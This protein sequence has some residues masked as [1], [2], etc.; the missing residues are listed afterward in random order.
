MMNDIFEISNLINLLIP[1]GTD[2]EVDM[3]GVKLHITKKDGNVKIETI[4]EFDDS[5]I[6]AEIKEFQAKIKELD[7]DTF[8]EVCESVDFNINEF[9]KL[10]EL[11]DIN[12]KQAEEIDDC[13]TKF[14]QAVCSNLQKKIED[15][16]SVYQRF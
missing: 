10:I 2:K 12:E 9:N 7:D 16:V 8:A 4:D 5:D 15:L 13:I 1:E 3:D 6:K 14:G 11:K